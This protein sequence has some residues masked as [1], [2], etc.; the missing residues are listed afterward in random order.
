M[1][2]DVPALRATL[3]E[4]YALLSATDLVN[5]RLVSDIAANTLDGGDSAAAK[6]FGTE[7]VVAAYGMLQEVLGARGLLRPGSH[8]AVIEGRVEALARRAQNNTFGGGSN[9]VMR[10]IVAARTLGMT[11]GAR[12]RPGVADAPTSP[13][14]AATKTPAETRS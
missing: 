4:V 6:V 13:D 5:L 8:G 3:A 12:R 2:F 14:A 10:E 1:L 11:L 7:G 9:E